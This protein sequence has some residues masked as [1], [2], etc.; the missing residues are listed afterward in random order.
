MVVTIMDADTDQDDGSHRRQNNTTSSVEGSR[1]H[2]D[3]SQQRV[4]D[5][6]RI[7]PSTVL[8]LYLSE[9]ETDLAEKTRRSHRYVIERFVDWCGEN[10][11]DAVADLRGRDLH[12]FRMDRRQEVSGNTLRSQLGTLRQFIRF[13]ESIEA[14]P[15]GL[16]DRIRM[17]EVERKVRDGRLQEEVADIVLEHLRKFQYASRDHALIRLLW[18]TAVRVGT[19][20]TF[21]VEDFDSEDRTLA[22]RHRPKTGT[23]LKNGQRAERLLALDPRTSETL[24]DYIEHNRPDTSDEHGRNPLFVTNRGRAGGSTIRRAVYRWT[25]PCQRGDD[26]PHN[27]NPESCEAKQKVHLAAQCPSTHSPHEVRRGAIS[28]LLNEE[29]PVRAISDRA[30]VGEDVLNKHYDARS[31]KERMETRR[32]FFE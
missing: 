11:V 19:V 23:P 24:A 26:C 4:S 25:R 8:D 29:T 14:A 3:K 6:D 2:P 32:S 30:D 9:R 21:D 17:P 10:D 28:F 15:V 20:R 22:V 27:R 13:A 16:G 7:Q 5:L 12:E 31:E 18:V 1:N